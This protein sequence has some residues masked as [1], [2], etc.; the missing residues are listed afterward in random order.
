VGRKAVAT[1]SVPVGLLLS[2]RAVTMRAD[3]SFPADG[4]FAV[5]ADCAVK[6]DPVKNEAKDNGRS[7][8]RGP[9]GARDECHSSHSPL[10]SAGWAV[11][12]RRCC[13]G[14][15]ATNGT[16]SVH[17]R[18]ENH[19]LRAS[20][21]YSKFLLQRGSAGFVLFECLRPLYRNWQT[22]RAQSLRES[23]G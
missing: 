19:G 10:A 21:R 18:A 20:M 3:A 15:S 14:F 23:N 13:D 5:G 17:N 16:A 6:A 8:P 9:H 22:I 4:R 12:L 11:G 7:G 2:Q 1:F